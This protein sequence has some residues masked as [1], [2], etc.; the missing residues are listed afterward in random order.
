MFKATAELIECRREEIIDACEYLCQ[1]IS[2]SDMTLKEISKIT[3]FSRPTIYNYFQSKEEI[4]LALIN[5]EFD[6]WNVELQ[7]ILS[8]NMGMTAEELSDR[9]AHSLENRRLLLKLLAV[10]VPAL[11]GSGEDERRGFFRN[12]FGRT[13]VLILRLLDMTC[14]RLPSAVQEQ[15]TQAFFS[16]IFGLDS[17]SE[18]FE[19]Q[20]DLLDR[21]GMDCMYQTVYSLTYNFVIGLLRA[22][23]A[24][25]I[26]NTNGRKEI[27]TRVNSIFD[28]H[29]IPFGPFRDT[30][31][32]LELRDEMKNEIRKDLLR[33]RV[34]N[35]V[36]DAE[37][38]DTAELR[39]RSNQPKY[40]RHNIRINL[41]LGLFSRELETAIIGHR[42]GDAFDLVIGGCTVRVEILS[43]KRK[44]ACEYSDEFVRSLEIPGVATKEEYLAYI[45]GKYIEL[46]TDGYL[47][48]HALELFDETMARS[49]IE[50]FDED[51]RLFIKDP[52]AAVD[53]DGVELEDARF[54]LELCLW[55]CVN[56]GI[57]YRTMDTEF[58]PRELTDLKDRVLRPFKE[59]L[60]DKCELIITEEQAPTP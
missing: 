56:R 8:E 11:E 15:L 50:Y 34:V 57:D 36:T 60:A 28:Y 35:E 20:K 47:E 2:Y 1:T 21:E 9:L 12:S 3:T 41:G 33:A 45:R 13:Q 52:D 27:R 31:P 43:L 19:S 5:R 44:S 40:N 42:T 49:D 25:R 59:F 48:C 4:F 38:G 17:I 10:S 26:A 30:M 6:R 55:D 16:F 22:S 37:P 29:D 24:Q 7:C 58:S 32:E 23:D 54:I 14:P 39:L 53:E 51:I 46:F 18:I